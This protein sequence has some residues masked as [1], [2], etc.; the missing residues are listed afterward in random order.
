MTDEIRTV[1]SPLPYGIEKLP[2]STSI[3][4]MTVNVMLPNGT[5]ITNPEQFETHETEDIEIYS[6]DQQ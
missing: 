2:S 4:F 3:G 6:E 5:V 1:K